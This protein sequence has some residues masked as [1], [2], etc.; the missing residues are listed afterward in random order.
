[1]AALIKTQTNS[2]MSTR[3]SVAVDDRTNTLLL[4]DNRRPAGG[5]APPGGE[6]DIPVRQVLI[7]A[8]SSSS[9]TTSSA[10]LG[11]RFG[12]TN[13]Q[14]NG[15]NGL[16][17]TSGTAAGTDSMTNT[18]LT[19]QNA[20]NTASTRTRSTHPGAAGRAG[21]RA[22]PDVRDPGRRQPL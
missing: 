10:D 22:G 15:Q 4:Q 14:K 16:V 11:A 19:G 18:F 6:L 7:E 1:M 8:A 12:L 13:W 3:G 17:S 21:A 9:A 2:L 20:I 5:R